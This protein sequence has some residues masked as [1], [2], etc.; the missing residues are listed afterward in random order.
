M[1]PSSKALSQM[2]LNIVLS[3]TLGLGMPNDIF[4][5]S[6]WFSMANCMA[7]LMLLTLPVP[8]LLRAFKHIKVASGAMPVLI[9]AVPSPHT[10]P[11]QCVP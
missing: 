1:T 9:P 5:I 3:V 11:A 7:L 2:R 8:L 4:M 6:A 10:V